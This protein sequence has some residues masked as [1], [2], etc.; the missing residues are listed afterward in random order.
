[1][2]IN[3]E[4][5]DKT[6]YDELCNA[7]D[8]AISYWCIEAK[9]VE[10]PEG[11]PPIIPQDGQLYE[12]ADYP[13]NEGAVLLRADNHRPPKGNPDGRYWR[14]DKAAIER[15]LGVMAVKYGKHFGDMMSQSGDAT[16]SDVFVQCC[17]FGKIVFG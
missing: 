13:M 7:H 16:T 14:L 4:V 5:P 2:I 9:F 3:I 15:G 17:V 10:P 6:V 8:H 12:F 11:S 1:M